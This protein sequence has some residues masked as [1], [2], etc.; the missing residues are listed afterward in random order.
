[1][2]LYNL[3]QWLH[4]VIAQKENTQKKTLNCRY[5]TGIK[6]FLEKLSQVRAP[7]NFTSQIPITGFAKTQ[8]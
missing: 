7:V 6:G 3:A 4:A 2:T 1:M 5:F 8:I